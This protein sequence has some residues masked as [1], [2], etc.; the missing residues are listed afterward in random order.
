MMRSRFRWL[1]VPAACVLS[2]AASISVFAQPK[3]PAT[4]DAGASLSGDAGALFAADAA[5][6]PTADLGGDASV[7]APVSTVK[8]VPPPPP[9]TQEQ[10][11]ALEALKNATD[12]YE[13][14]AREYRD[15]VNSIIKLH[16]EEKKR[17]VLSGLDRE[18]AI[19]KEELRKARETAIQRL[20]DFVNRYSGANAHPEATP[21][22]MY[23]LAALYE[24]R[25][26]GEDANEDEL[27]Q[28]LRPAIALYKRIIK[29]FPAYRE[30]AGVYYFLGHALVDAH[31][32]DEGQQVWR[33][34]VCHNK[35]A[36][37]TPP[38]PKDPEVDSIVPMPQDQPKEFWNAWR[39]RYNDYRKIRRG[40]PETTYV[41]PYPAD[42]QPIAQPSLRPGEEPKYVAEVWWQI[43]NWEFDGLDLRGGATDDE[44][45]PVW[46][47]NRAASAYQQALKFKKIPVY[48]VS[49]Y[50][51]AW[52]LFK[53]QR[54]E[55]ATREFVRL[56]LHTEELEKQGQGVADFRSEAYTYIAGSLTNVDFVGPDPS[57]PYIQRPDIVDSEP[58]PEVAEKKLHV[59][60]DRVKDP[61]LVPQD[62]PWTIEIYKALASEFRSLNHFNNAIETYELILKKWPMD[63]TACDVQNS[64]AETYDQMLVTKKQGTPEFD[65]LSAKA[66][67]ART[68]LASYIGTTPWTDANKENP[69][70]LQNCERLVRGGLRQAAAAH[71][72]KGKALLVAASTTGSEQEALDYL[73]RSLAEYKLAAIGWA[74]YLKQDE[75]AP[76]AYESRFWLADARNKQVRVGYLLFKRKPA[77]FQE[78]TRQEIEGA[79]AAAADVRD[80]NEDDKYVDVAGQ[81]VVEVAD[82]MR[83]L[84]Y[85]RFD[86]TKGSQGVERREAVQLVGEGDDVKVVQVPIPPSVQQAL[87]ARDE[88][89]QRVPLDK[90]PI[91]PDEKVRL[92]LKYQF[93]VADVYF[94]YGQFKEAKARFEPIYKENCGK[95]PYGYR[96]WEKL[97]SMSNKERDIDRSRALA[98]AERTKSCAVSDE[99]TKS[100]GLLVN[101]T[102]QEAAYVDA[103]R[104][105]QA[106]QAAPSGPEKQK[107]W[108]EAAELYESALNAA[109]ARDEAPEAAMNA[110]YAYKQIGDF[111]KAIKMYDKFI[112]EYGSEARLSALEK[113]DPKTKTAPDPKKYKERVGYL[114]KAYDVLGTTYYGFFNYPKAAET[115]DKIATNERFDE[116]QRK[117]SARNAMIL[118][119]NIGQR[120]KML[121]QYR[122]VTKLKPTADEKANYDY[123]VANYD[124]QQWNKDGADT[125]TN[126]TT[127]LAAQG[128]LQGFYN[129]NKGNPA[130]A[131]YALEAA[132]KIAKMK[133]AGG[134]PDYR[135]WFKNTI[136]AW[137]FMKTRGTIGKDGKA[138]ALSA[139]FVDYGAEA[140]FT[141]LDEEIHEKFDYETGHHRYATMSAEEVM[142]KFDPKTKTFVKTGKYPAAAKEAD[143]YDQR[144]QKIVAT[145]PSLEF[146]PA[147]LARQGSLYD[148]LRTGLDSAGGSQF[149]LFTPQQEKLLKTM[150]QSGN[151]ALIDQ[152]AEIKGAVKQGWRDKREQ[153]INANDEILVRRYAQAVKL[154]QTYNVRTAWVTRAVARLAYLTDIIG[155]QKMRQYVTST[156]DPTD[157]S[158][159]RKLSYTDNMYVQMRPGLPATPALTG[160]AA[161]LPVA[162]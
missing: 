139:P 8:K 43:G 124:Y 7:L 15:T 132:W 23:R 12:A 17:N 103:R 36:Y 54:Y 24:E 111:N 47:L 29:E 83:D 1:T 3:L 147:A 52:T 135:A 123:L 90:D 155:N 72:N 49:L 108:K 113:G 96:A 66:L 30:L 70:A 133:K 160:V 58:R 148:S 127:R 41:D 18:I 138:E 95:N 56:L 131:K 37:P 85:D 16:Y 143:G 14:G 110:A 6:L 94:V 106:A 98:E 26:R 125:G 53:Q 11:A 99:Q 109:P 20:E 45:I 71:T 116:M 19:E 51:Y 42:C 129:G 55:A 105:F 87:N 25:A 159:V 4:G 64:I 28:N 144:L 61:S 75:N 59:A 32:I 62:K 68:G 120:E 60:L 33:S 57:D 145:Y 77:A 97:I 9:P 136:A 141:L 162:P 81:M 146:V 13:R 63:P 34:L 149:K 65:A 78:P 44:P 5:A 74:G 102:L 158:K 27:P 130:A 153:E 128:A 91:E 151:D 21:D 134:D 152:A 101:P 112:T 118:Y 73:T 117:E 156:T 76:D 46:T 88:Y 38:D 67:E 119:A 48:S 114:Y 154:A 126:R 100:A 35:F 115:Y 80:S 22:A 157:P 92:G 69:A 50:K 86:R 107:L 2:L 104:K 89:V 161:P 31:R 140:E 39:A 137:D 79:K 40:N 150:E 10:V 82:I 142:G 122:I 93:Y 84:E 121:A